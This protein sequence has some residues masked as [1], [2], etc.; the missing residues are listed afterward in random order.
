M[1][2]DVNLVLADPVVQLLMVRNGVTRE[3]VEEL[4]TTLQLARNNGDT[5]LVLRLS[6]NTLHIPLFGPD[7]FFGQLSPDSGKI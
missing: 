3:D 4:L 6:A 5:R 7:R 2:D 1:W